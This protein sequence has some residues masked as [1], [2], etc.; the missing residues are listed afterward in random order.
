MIHDAHCH[1]FSSRFFETLA[2]EKGDLSES[3]KTDAISL[4]LGWDSPGQ[5]Q[6]LA[7][8]WVAELDKNGVTRA[9][10]IASIPGD[11]ESVAIAVN[12][13]PQR[14]VGMFMLDPTEHTAEY[15]TRLAFEEF[16]L[17]CVCL[18]PAMHH[19]RLDDKRTLKIFELT[20]SRPDTSVFVHCG[21]LSVGIRKKLGLA[22]RFD[23]RLGDPLALH[24]IASTYPHLP[25]IIPHFGAGFFHQTLMVADLCPNIY[26]DTS[27]SNAW[28]KYQPGITL[29]DAF[30]HALNVVGPQRLL[31]G[32][33]SSFFPRG[34]HRTVWEDQQ[35]ILETFGLD[36]VDMD[37]IF[38]HN[39]E[40][41]F[42]SLA[43]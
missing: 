35:T 33:D 41:V 4:T 12:R 42:G 20:A 17:R 43:L 5:P 19:Y 27:S 10:L 18:F 24:L 38:C 34:W 22:S 2:R 16:G 26:L 23:I 8:R 36:R 7:D 1:F 37:R 15:R 39:F 40:T 9:A 31:F 14:F 29:A 3:S 25:I 28:I 30:R 6:E 21:A 13:H 11:E 32:T